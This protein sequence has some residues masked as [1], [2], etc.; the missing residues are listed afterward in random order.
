MVFG[1][2]PPASSFVYDKTCKWVG[3]RENLIQRSWFF[4]PAA[5]SFAKAKLARWRSGGIILPFGFW[6]VVRQLQVLQG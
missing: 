1:F 4:R 6:F 3:G 2:R 5:S